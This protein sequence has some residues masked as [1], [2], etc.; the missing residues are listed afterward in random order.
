MARKMLNKANYSICPSM[1]FLSPG[2]GLN[3]SRSLMHMPGTTKEK[4]C[5]F[6]P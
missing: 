5:V 4:A 2:I 3:V 1:H 6:G